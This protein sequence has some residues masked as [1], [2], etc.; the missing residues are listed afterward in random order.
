MRR[1]RTL[2][3]AGEVMRREFIALAPEQSQRDAWAMMR[4][5]RLRELPV[6]SGGRLI[7]LLRY[8]SLAPRPPV[9]EVEARVSEA[10][11]TAVSIPVDCNLRRAARLMLEHAMG[12]LPVVDETDGGP[13]LL[14]VLTE[15]DL[16][17][18]AYA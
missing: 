2:R 8:R 4:L 17:Q 7:G 15:R 14:G 3:T 12:A 18:L 11:E 9:G 1:K 16:I 6:V 5:A 13:R 10:M